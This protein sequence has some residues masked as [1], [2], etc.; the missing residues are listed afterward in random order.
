MLVR[1]ELIL[2]HWVTVVA[3]LAAAAALSGCG[4]SQ[5]ASA[6]AGAAGGAGGR[7]GGGP[8]V[9]V[10]VTPVQRMSVQ[11]YV[12]LAGTLNSPDQAKVSCEVAGVVR[13]VMV[14]IGTEV[15][16]G[17]PLVRIEPRE[18]DL[19]LARAESALRQTYAQLGMHNTMALDAAPPPDE[20]V[21]SV[22]TAVANLDDAKA[23]MTRAEALSARGILSPVDKQAA[24]TRL[25]V[26]E[27]GFQSA[28]DNV[29]SLK[30]QLQDRRAAFELAQKK[31][32]DTIVKAPIAGTIVD[33][34]VQPGEFISERT[35]VATVVQIHPLKLRTGV[36]ER[37]AGVIK[38]GQPVEFRV[39]SYGDE[40]FHGK[41]AYVSPAID[42]TMRTFQIEALVDNA[43]ARLKP[44]FFAKGVIFTTKDEGVLAVPDAAV[45]T[46]AGVSSV[47]VVRNNRI[48]QQQVTLGV[49]QGDLWEVTDGLKG[50]ET[51]ANRRLNELATGTAVRTGAGPGKGGGPGAGS[52]T[53]PGGGS[54][55]G[56][57][58]R[59]GGE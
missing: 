28:L 1:A 57:G 4:G 48:T 40:V 17:Q 56:Q 10:S 53:G 25:K 22:R 46:L 44:G 58:G 50:D 39:T 35:A 33:R 5:G 18:L 16:Q 9:E 45:S 3:S 13:D 41:V 51:L 34:Y 55:R 6:A 8:A 59:R 14:E 52:R 32:A 30:A 20:Q 47:Y 11:R 15:R 7:R 27:A 38:P 21:A 49:R 19:A 31:V 37:H 26:A 23:A 12:D 36:Q 42:Q 54:R 43:N 2:R 29:R 24:E